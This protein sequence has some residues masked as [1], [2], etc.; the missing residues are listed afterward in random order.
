MR[1]IEALYVLVFAGPLEAQE[2]ALHARIVGR[3]IE[4][5]AALDQPSI[6]VLDRSQVMVL[7]EQ[8]AGDFLDAAGV[9]GLEE[10]MLG[11]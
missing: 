5:A 2:P 8:L 11:G 6:A 9:L 10:P 7:S 3:M 1:G 4:L